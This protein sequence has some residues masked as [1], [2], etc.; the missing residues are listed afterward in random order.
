MSCEAR[1]RGSGDV[2]C[3]YERHVFLAAVEQNE[4]SQSIVWVQD[5]EGE[6]LFCFL[7]SDP[8]IVGLLR[9]KSKEISV[10]Q[11]NRGFQDIC[12]DYIC[13]S[14]SAV[15]WAPTYRAGVMGAF[16]YV[17]RRCLDKTFLWCR[18]GRSYG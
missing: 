8:I 4:R 6:N 7:F 14:R 2:L 5:R 9:Q 11:A 17:A 15:H 13:R 18:K 1:A 3:I 10:A 12:R 16:F